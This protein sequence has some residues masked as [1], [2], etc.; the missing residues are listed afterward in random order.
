[1]KCF[2]ALYAVKAWGRVTLE[3]FRRRASPGAGLR[4]S[5]TVHVSSTNKNA[6]I[7]PT[8][9]EPIAV[10]FRHAF[11][12]IISLIITIL[13]I[14]DSTILD[15][16]QQQVSTGENRKLDMPDVQAKDRRNGAESS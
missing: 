12:V 7:D 3:S 16:S 4:Y 15:Q 9:V 13:S 14:M 1:M 2:E 5:T 11:R 8:R 6:A 10:V